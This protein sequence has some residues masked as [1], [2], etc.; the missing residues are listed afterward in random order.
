MINFKRNTPT[1]DTLQDL[2]K[3]IHKIFTDQEYYYTKADLEKIKSNPDNLI[4]YKK[5]E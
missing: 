4:I 3:T 2:Y 1:E 5:K